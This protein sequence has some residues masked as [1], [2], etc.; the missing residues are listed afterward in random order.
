MQQFL[1]EKNICHPSITIS[2]D[3]ALSDI[4]LF[5][6]LKM[7]LKVTCFTAMVSKQLNATAEFES[8]GSLLPLL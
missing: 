4:R 8:N 7:G 1:A 2:P 3:L 6:I 5:P